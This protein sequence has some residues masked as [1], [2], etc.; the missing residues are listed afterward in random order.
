MRFP[1]YFG[2]AVN[3][4]T[5]GVFACFGWLDGD[6]TRAHVVTS[7]VVAI[8]AGLVASSLAERVSLRGSS[9]DEPYVHRF[10]SV[11]KLFRRTDTPASR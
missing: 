8:A 6:P 11:I 10:K 1:D 2:C 5:W 7:L 9:P 3:L 4:L